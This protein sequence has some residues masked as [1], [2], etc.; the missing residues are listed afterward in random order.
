MTLQKPPFA[1]TPFSWFLINVFLF[2]WVFLVFFTTTKKNKGWRV[3]VQQRNLAGSLAGLLLDILKI[4]DP[5][6]K[7]L[8]LPNLV[9]VSKL[10]VCNFYAGL[11]ICALLRSF[12]LSFADICALLNP[13][14][15]GRV[16]KRTKKNKKGR[17]SPDRETPPV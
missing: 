17:T 5:H 6:T 8:V 11:L 13:R 14:K 3:R 9:V 4:L 1:K 2:L 15:I 12:A 10:V 7:I 16:P